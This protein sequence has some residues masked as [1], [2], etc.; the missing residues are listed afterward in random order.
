MA[1]LLVVVLGASFCFFFFLL[2]THDYKWSRLGPYR[3]NLIEGWGMTIAVSASALL[4]SSVI[5][6]VLTMGQLSEMRAARWFSRIYVEIIR[7]TPLLVQILIGYY[8]VADA[9]HLDSKFVV[10]VFL[11]AAFAGAYL[12]EIFRGGI[13]SIPESQIESARAIGLT[14]AQ[15]YRYVIIPQAVRRVLPATAGQFAN[16]IKDSSLLYVI[17]LGEFTM[18]ARETNANTLLTF[19][20]YLPLALGYLVLTLPISFWTRRLE[21]Q[22]R[23]AT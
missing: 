1:S 21:Q 8:L 10:G 20:A 22:F 19:E 17:G 3:G 4:L 15:T 9:L 12:S 14:G 7:G 16:L 11:L 13:E 18:Q 5:G 6:S 23:Y 2:V